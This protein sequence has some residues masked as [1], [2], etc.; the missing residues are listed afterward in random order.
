MRMEFLD[1]P[2]LNWD[3]TVYQVA[4]K[5]IDITE[6]AASER[7]AEENFHWIYVCRKDEPE[8]EKV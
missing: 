3:I 6:I 2:E 4:K 8:E 5:T 7:N 1:C